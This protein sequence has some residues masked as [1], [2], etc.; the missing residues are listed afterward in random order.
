MSDRSLTI[1]KL[2][3]GFAILSIFISGLKL[4]PVNKKYSSILKKASNV[5]FGTDKDLE[6]VIEYLE[7]RLEERSFY[8]FNLIKQ[9]MRLT[10]V[11]TLA[12]GSGPQSRRSRSALRVAMIYQSQSK[13]KAQLNYRGK[14]Y[15][16]IEKKELPSI[17]KVVLIDNNQVVIRKDN[18]L[19]SYPAPGSKRQTP[20]EIESIG[21]INK[22][23]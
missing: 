3:V 17:G 7:K 9:P 2:V 21:S 13:F 4:R 10:N 1:W 22:I 20:I 23:K 18:K 5:Q 16:V 8:Q 6:G 11:L 15:S 14:I 12:D 19:L